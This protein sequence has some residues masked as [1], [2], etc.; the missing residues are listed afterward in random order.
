MSLLLGWKLMDK[1]DKMSSLRGKN[2]VRVLDKMSNPVKDA[3]YVCVS[4]YISSALK[5]TKRVK[6]TFPVL[7]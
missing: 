7:F 6:A 4:V 1:V 5:L 2:E 3:F